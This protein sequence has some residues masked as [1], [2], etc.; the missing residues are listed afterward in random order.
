MRKYLTFGIITFLLIATTVY[1]LNDN[2]DIKSEQ[3]SYN[4][5]CPYYDEKTDT[6]NCP[7]KETRNHHRSHHNNCY[8]NQ[9]RCLNQNR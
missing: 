6:Q 2:E 7:Y 3:I 1:A 8:N 9:R 4:Q 5:N